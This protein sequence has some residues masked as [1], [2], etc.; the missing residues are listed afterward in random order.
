V[1]ARAFV[2]PDEQTQVYS[3]L[4]LAQS[5]FAFAVEY[6][7]Q[8]NEDFQSVERE[9]SPPYALSLERQG[10]GRELEDTEQTL[11]ELNQTVVT[12]E[13]RRLDEQIART[14]Q[15]IQGLEASQELIAMNEYLATVDHRRAEIN[16][17]PEI[18]CGNAAS[19][20]KHL[21]AARE[22]LGDRPDIASP[23]PRGAASRATT[24]GLL[25]KPSSL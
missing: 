17:V 7:G 19:V 14:R 5:Q 11:R 9:H 15:Q 16:N 18:I 25:S 13:S 22:A 4:A 2:S 24:L 21:R 3:A 6:H 23:R 10:L 1:V 8:R 20:R 12:A